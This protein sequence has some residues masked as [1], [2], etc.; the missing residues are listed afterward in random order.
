MQ[1]KINTGNTPIIGKRFGR[2]EALTEL[3]RGGMGAVYV[4][5]LKSVGT[6]R[7]L[8]AIKVIHAH[9]TSDERYVKLFHREADIA[10]RLHH[11]N[12]VPV[13]ELGEEEG[14]H[15]LVM[16]YYPSVP[17]LDLMKVA[18]GRGQY[19]PV[20]V[21]AGIVADACGALDEF[22]KLT[23][24]DGSPL[25][26]VHRDATPSNLL[27]GQDGSVKLTDFGVAKAMGGNFENLTQA[28]SGF[29]GKLGYLSPEQSRGKPLDGRSDIFTMGIV[30]HELLS[31]KKLFK[32]NSPAEMLLA[33][34]GEPIP[35]LRVL[36]PEVPHELAAAVEKALERDVT[37]RY[38]TAGEFRDAL[39]KV[40]RAHPEEGRADLVRALVGEVFD[41]R[42]K[43]VA[44][45]EATLDANGSGG[46][47]VAGGAGR[48]AS[49]QISVP[50]GATPAPTPAST[51][52]GDDKTG[53][54]G[55]PVDVYALAGAVTAPGGGTVTSVIS[56]Q[57]T[58]AAG[59]S[60]GVRW[61]IAL[62][63]GALVGSAAGVVALVLSAPR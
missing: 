2:Y 34:Q 42:R 39:L 45:A 52:I 20:S 51:S 6:M 11:P 61:A 53:V 24:E 63:S 35:D 60:G 3:A 5:R 47:P 22:H 62:A 55:G 18:S 33:L 1:G 57:A 27:I 58:A 50:R 7:R 56:P 14:T 38:Q 21:A 54:A 37:K 29:K 46:A 10:S 48:N 17:L 26:L 44:A 40:L 28:G 8:V 12:V 9:L 31:S 49:G 15:F 43:E 25:N 19:F 41:S 32:K 16:E 36:R 13:L 30:L 23:D 4:G 59:P